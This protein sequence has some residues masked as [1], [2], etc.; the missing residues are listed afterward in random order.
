MNPHVE[1]GEKKIPALGHGTKIVPFPEVSL[2][3]VEQTLFVKY[4]LSVYIFLYKKAH[5][6]FSDVPIRKFISSVGDF[7]LV[8][9]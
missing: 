2:V 8:E 3:D 9:V 5:P 6:Q 4:A 7:F 1:A